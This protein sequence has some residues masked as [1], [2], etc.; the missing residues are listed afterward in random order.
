VHEILKFLDLLTL[1]AN[2]LGEIYHES[3]NAL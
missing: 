2:L 1:L 3:E